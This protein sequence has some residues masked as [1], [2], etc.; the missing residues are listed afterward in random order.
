MQ[1]VAIQIDQVKGVVDDAN[2]ELRSQAALAIAEAGALLHQAERR[3][4]ILIERN[5]FS[6]ENGGFRVHKVRQIVQLG[7]LRGQFVLVAG[8]EPKAAVIE[9]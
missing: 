1:V 6:V 8:H 5:D 3:T 7:I 2:V 4:S 9:E